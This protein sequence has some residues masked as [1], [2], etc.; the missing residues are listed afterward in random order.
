MGPRP[1]EY[2]L[3]H[4]TAADNLAGLLKVLTRALPCARLD[5]ATALARRFDHFETLI[6]GDTNRLFNINVFAGLACLNRHVRV[7]MV[8]SR[9][10]NEVDPRVRQDFA[11][12]LDLFCL[13]SSRAHDGRRSFAMGP[14]DIA[15]S[16]DVDA[17]LQSNLQVLRPHHADANEA[18]GGV[19]LGLFEFACDQR[20]GEGGTRRPQE[21]APTKR[22][23]VHINSLCGTQRD[24]TL[25]LRFDWPLH[26]RRESEWQ[27]DSMLSRMNKCSVEGVVADDVW[28]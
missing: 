19:L 12:I 3:P 28:L 17:L 16:S 20:S 13:L 15:N 5:P 23:V 7:P 14:I 25:E 9:D 27:K 10:A 4:L 11:K 2:H 8:G 6:N 26:R 22:F 18:A 21:I 1:C 24:V